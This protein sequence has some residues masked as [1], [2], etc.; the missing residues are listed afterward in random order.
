[1]SDATKDYNGQRNRFPLVHPLCELSHIASHSTHQQ[2]SLMQKLFKPLLLKIITILHKEQ[3][4]SLLLSLSLLIFSLSIS[5]LF[6]FA[7]FFL[8]IIICA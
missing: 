5:F 3:L 2:E 6:S 4:L 7:P 1:M 8:L